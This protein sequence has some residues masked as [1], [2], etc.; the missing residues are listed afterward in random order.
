MCTF[1]LAQSHS[2]D[3]ILAMATNC[4]EHISNGRLVT[5]GLNFRDQPWPGKKVGW[6]AVTITGEVLVSGLPTR[7]D[8]IE[9][10]L[11]ALQDDQED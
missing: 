7:E 4:F 1:P 8:A 5:W 10:A 6:E 9:A 2:P 3:N 11:E